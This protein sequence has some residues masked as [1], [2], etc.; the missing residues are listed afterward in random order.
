MIFHVKV[1]TP[2]KSVSTVLTTIV[3]G[4]NQVESFVPFSK[5]EKKKMKK[6]WWFWY[7]VVPETDVSGESFFKCEIT[8]R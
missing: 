7:N 5:N 3:G 6:T 1:T 4:D 8:S 2:L